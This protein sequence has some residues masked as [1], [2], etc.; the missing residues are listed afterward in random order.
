MN[1]ETEW[2]I[3][4][5]GTVRL[6]KLSVCYSPEPSTAS[7]SFCFVCF[8]WVQWG[9][10]ESDSS[11]DL[12]S[13]FLFSFGSPISLPTGLT[14]PCHASCRYFLPLRVVLSVHQ[15]LSYMYSCC[16][17][18]ATGICSSSARMVFCWQLQPSLSFPIFL[19]HILH[20]TCS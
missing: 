19:H 11:N 13:S 2:Q 4:C 1:A 12:L 14:M 17:A 15:Q 6:I 20:N 10:R 16:L 7:G 18:R 8:C 3:V 9:E 5:Q